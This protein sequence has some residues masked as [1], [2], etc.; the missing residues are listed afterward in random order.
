MCGGDGVLRLF[1]LHHRV[2]LNADLTTSTYVYDQRVFV[3]HDSRDWERWEHK[4]NSKTTIE[5]RKRSAR[6]VSPHAI[7]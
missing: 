7:D 1:V 5:I 4:G 6:T 2:S 3:Q